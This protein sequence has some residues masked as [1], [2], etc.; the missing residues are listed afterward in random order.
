MLLFLLALLTCLEMLKKAL[1]TVI[2]LVLASPLSAFDVSLD[3]V[4]FGVLQRAITET[5]WNVGSALLSDPLVLNE[6]DVLKV[7]RW[8]YAS[9]ST[10]NKNAQELNHIAA[11]IYSTH[12]LITSEAEE[13]DY[14]V[15]PAIIQVGFGFGIGEDF[16][17]TDDATVVVAP[18]VVGETTNTT[19][20]TE[21]YTY[22]PLVFTQNGDNYAQMDYAILRK[23]AATQS[24]YLTIPSSPS[25]NFE[26]KLQTSTDLQTW[27]P[28]TSGIFNYGD[29][30]RFF[31]LVVE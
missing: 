14:I 25:G 19:S 27:T 7:L 12:G 13:A 5:S 10:N 23:G 22:E 15:G 11:S 20:T 9:N 16:V 2:F 29:N 30:T 24:S 28:T 8:D 17:V 4:E 1:Q 21:E 26:V 3:G 18:N 31:R 6:G